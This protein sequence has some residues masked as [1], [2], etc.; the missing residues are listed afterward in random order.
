MILTGRA[1]VAEITRA[2]ATAGNMEA[3]LTRRNNEGKNDGSRK[4]R[5]GRATQVSKMVQQHR[6]LYEK[7]RLQGA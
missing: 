1:D 4:D 3:M 7:S 5:T 2:R 6:W